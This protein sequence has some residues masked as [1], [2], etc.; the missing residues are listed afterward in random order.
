[1]KLRPAIVLV[2]SVV[3]VSVLSYFKP[4]LSY[5][6]VTHQ[7]I[8][9]QATRDSSLDKILRYR[10]GITERGIRTQLFDGNT[11]KTVLDWISE[12]SA[13]EDGY[14]IFPPLPLGRFLNHFPPSSSAVDSLAA[15][16]AWDFISQRSKWFRRVWNRRLMSA[17][18]RLVGWLE[19]IFFPTPPDSP[20]S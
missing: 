17:V 4:V 1:M 9:E 2:A 10:L 3:L 14:S 19:L 7:A 13:L 8:S 12:G 18:R 5:E 20:R 15:G 6:V 11:Q 16:E